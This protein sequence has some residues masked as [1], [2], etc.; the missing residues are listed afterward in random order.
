M[1]SPG[2]HVHGGDFS[3]G[4]AIGIEAQDISGQGGGVAGDV[5][6]ALWRHGGNGGDGLFVDGLGQNLLQEGLVG[7]PA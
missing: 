6:N 7:L 3:Q 2:E 1:T 4:I 5:H